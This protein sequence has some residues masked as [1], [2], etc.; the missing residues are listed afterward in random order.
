MARNLG[1]WLPLIGLLVAPPPVA[2][3]PLEEIRAS[4]IRCDG[5]CPTSVG[6]VVVL[7]AHGGRL[8]T[9]YCGATLVAPDLVLTAA[10]CLGAQYFREG[11]SCEDS[12]VV[13]FPARRVAAVCARGAYDAHTRGRGLGPERTGL[14]APATAGAHGAAAIG[15][16]RRRLRGRGF[17]GALRPVSGGSDGR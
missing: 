16:F 3:S 8:F 1:V 10:H 5:D 11:A 13:S 17:D 2:A 4:T 15:G 14:R 7:T 6:A 9:N 12:V